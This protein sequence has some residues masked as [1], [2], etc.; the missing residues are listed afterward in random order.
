MTATVLW[1]TG[2]SGSGK[3]TIADLVA[4][5]LQALGWSTLTLDGDVVRAASH[6]DL[7]F[8]P[9]DIRENNR[10]IAKKCF[11]HGTDY[12]FVLVPVI[13]P[14]ADSRA[15]A[16]RM[17][18]RGFREIYVKASAA[19]CRRRD[20]KGLYA[21]VDAGKLENMIGVSPRVPYET[22]QDPDLELDT[23]VLGPEECATRLVAAAKQWKGQG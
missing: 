9:P 20:P 11:D 3:S 5:Q 2:R 4:R 17:V 22:P 14:F 8:T 15:E 19:A 7:G 10:R 18:G 1:L 13:S 12:D 21:R 16:R 23:E 6:K